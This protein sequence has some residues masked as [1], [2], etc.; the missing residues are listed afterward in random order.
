[1]IRPW[2]ASELSRIA[3]GCR[4]WERWSRLL[5][6]TADIYEIDTADRLCMWTATVMHESFDTQR[7]EE[8]LNFTTS[9]RIRAVWPRRFPTDDAARPFVRNPER[10][11]ERVYGG[12]MGNGPAGSGDA[13]KFRGRG[14]IQITGREMYARAAAAL[15]QPLVEQPDLLASNLELAALSAGWYWSQAGCNALA[16]TG[17]FEAVTRAINGGAVGMADRMGALRRCR[18]VM[19][20]RT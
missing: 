8:S 1:M 4:D 20:R 12:R 3:P 10:L 2:S 17:N 5:G 14:L 7:L 6:V 18:L 13:W 11:A 16:D 9:A 15:N 19:G